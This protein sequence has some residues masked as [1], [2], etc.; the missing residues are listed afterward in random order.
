LDA[1][2]WYRILTMESEQ[3]FFILFVTC[4]LVGVHYGTGRHHWDLEDEEIEA[5][6]KVGPTQQPSED[7]LR[8]CRDTILTDQQQY[9]WL[10]YL[11]Y[12]TTMIAS[13]ISIGWFLLRIT[14]RR[15]DIWIIY[16]VM[17]VTVLT[18]I[19]FFFVTLFQCNPIAYFWDTSLNGSCIPV[20]VII[21]LT[22]L[23]SACSV[24]CDFTFALL[25]VALIWNLNM[26]RK[27]K[28]AL[29]PIMTMACV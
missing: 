10:C 14:I 18:G 26:D 8:V 19:V 15:I 6:K 23:Y 11:W 22:Y 9:W 21:A 29:V 27:S 7:T 24:I 20:E 16:S 4:A 25:P 12:C 3:I 17:L 5:A 1:W 2:E 28:I 13:K